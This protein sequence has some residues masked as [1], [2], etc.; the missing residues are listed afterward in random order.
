M[1]SDPTVTV[2]TRLAHR[3]APTPE[4]LAIATDQMLRAQGALDGGGTARVVL[5]GDKITKAWI[6]K[7]VKGLVAPD[8][9]KLTPQADGF[10]VEPA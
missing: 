10:L 4:H 8:G 1:A 2:G 7:L 3:K 6:A 9:Y 5:E